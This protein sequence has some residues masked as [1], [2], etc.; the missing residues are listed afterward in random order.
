M[1]FGH[2]RR[3]KYA[4]AKTLFTSRSVNPLIVANFSFQ[5]IENQDNNISHHKKCLQKNSRYLRKNIYLCSQN[6]GIMRRF[7]C[8]SAV[9]FLL[10]LAFAACRDD[11]GVDDTLYRLQARFQRLDDGEAVRRGTEVIPETLPANQGQNQRRTRLQTDNKGIV[12]RTLN[13]TKPLM[14][15]RR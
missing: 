11:G 13:L 2:S 9:V 10:T 15:P 1:L 4:K 3:Q 14:R 7:L 6:I 5:V 12:T 8:F